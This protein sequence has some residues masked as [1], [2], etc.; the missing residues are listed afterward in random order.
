[1]LMRQQ[2]VVAEARRLSKSVGAINTTAR[3]D[4]ALK[5]YDE[6]EALMHEERRRGY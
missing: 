6:A 5:A 2:D 4:R 1:M 3:L